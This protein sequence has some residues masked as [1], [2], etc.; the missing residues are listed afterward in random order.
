MVNLNYYSQDEGEHLRE[1]WNK[2]IGEFKKGMRFRIP[3]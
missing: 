3:Q 2:H 1:I